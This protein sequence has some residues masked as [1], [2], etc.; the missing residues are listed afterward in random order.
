[1][2]EASKIFFEELDPWIQDVIVDLFVS[3][4]EGKRKAQELNVSPPVGEG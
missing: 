1:M 3:I 2:D 4:I